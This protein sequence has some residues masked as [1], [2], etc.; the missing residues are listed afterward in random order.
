MDAWRHQ[1]PV[2]KHAIRFT[3][4]D[5][6]CVV[7][8]H[9]G[10]VVAGLTRNQAKSLKGYLMKVWNIVEDL[11]DKVAQIP[12]LAASTT[13]VAKVKLEGEGKAQAYLP[14]DGAALL[15]LVKKHGLK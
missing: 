2:Y 14:T 1:V 8:D 5:D 15:E 7:Y 4:T 3:E 12:T 6:G 10:I 11:E 9:E 13:E